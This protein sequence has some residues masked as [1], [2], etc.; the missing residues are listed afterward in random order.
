[1][2]N[3]GTHSIFIINSFN[4]T[5]QKYYQKI[6]INKQSGERR[7]IHSI[8]YPL[9]ILIPFN[10]HH[11]FKFDYSKLKPLKYQNDKEIDFSIPP[12]LC[13]WISYIDAHNEK[14]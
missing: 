6:Q 7:T 8:S 3:S 4:T 1:M 13:I 5:H 12:C 10:I 9:N 11:H 2:L 14:Y